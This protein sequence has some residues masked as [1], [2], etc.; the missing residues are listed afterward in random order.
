MTWFRDR[1]RHRL[2]AKGIS[3]KKDYKAKKT[4]LTP[5]KGGLA[6]KTDPKKYNK[7]NLQKGTEM[8]MKH[9]NDRLVAQRI[10]MD[11]LEEHPDYYKHL[12]KMEKNLTK[13]EKRLAEKEKR[14][15]KIRGTR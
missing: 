14:K 6:D 13:R 3:T 1:K 7:E 11:H 4:Y 8:E 10:A 12:Q 15:Q 9:T 5:L 2:A